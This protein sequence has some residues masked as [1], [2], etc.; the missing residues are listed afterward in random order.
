ML[1]NNSIP[2]ASLCGMYDVGDSGTITHAVYGFAPPLSERSAE[3]SADNIT[4]HDVRCLNACFRLVS[5]AA[6]R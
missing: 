4:R 2:S 5:L 6:C 1:R 3:R